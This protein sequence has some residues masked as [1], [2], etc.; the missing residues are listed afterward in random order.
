M[1]VMSAVR[2]LTVFLVLGVSMP[3]LAVDGKTLYEDNCAKC[4]G[5]TGR[6]D[7]WRGYL[8]FA[9]ELADSKWQVRHSDAEIREDI[10]RGPRIMPSFRD[11]FSDEDMKAVIAYIR[12]MRGK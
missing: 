8:Y 12:S 7:T 10:E 9:E 6:A 5:K 11:K 3:A 4:H 1:R 2:G